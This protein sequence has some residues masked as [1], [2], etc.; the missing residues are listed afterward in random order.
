MDRRG[1]LRSAIGLPLLA[2]TS[3]IGAAEY[4]V[5]DE[6]RFIFTQMCAQPVEDGVRSSIWA[7]ITTKKAATAQKLFAAALPHGSVNMYER[8]WHST[9]V[10]FD[11]PDG[12]L[13]SANVNFYCLPEHP[14]AEVYDMLRRRISSV[15]IT[16]AWLDSP[17]RWPAQL[18]AL[19]SCRTGRYPKAPL[20][21]GVYSPYGFFDVDIGSWRYVPS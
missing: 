5:F 1:V 21:P 13:I 18:A 17:T 15:A 12:T 10:A 9:T 2:A 7:F 14:D 4:E 6:N 20:N 8:F 11:G 16:S 19:V 3:H